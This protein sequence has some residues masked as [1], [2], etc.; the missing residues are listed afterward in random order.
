MNGPK[1]PGELGHGYQEGLWDG[2]SDIRRVSGEGEH[3]AGSGMGRLRRGHNRQQQRG[4][5]EMYAADAGMFAAGHSKS[6]VRRPPSF[7]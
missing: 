4:Y 2:R 3:A 7:K 5:E 1:A 6:L